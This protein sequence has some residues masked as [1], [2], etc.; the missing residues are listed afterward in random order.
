MVSRVVL[1][2]ALV[3]LAL[4][5]GRSP[6][7]EVIAPTRAPGTP[8]ITT[9]ALPTV[10]SATLASLDA[11]LKRLQEQTALLSPLT[12]AD[13]RMYALFRD[14]EA[15]QARLGAV[16]SATDAEGRTLYDRL[17]R[18]TTQADSL[19]RLLEQVNRQAPRP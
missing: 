5:C 18:M 12:S 7:T 17:A 16:L 14:L 15:S 13:P 19:F 11:S 2:A 10:D 6:R 3:T 8:D 9:L 1:V 4:G